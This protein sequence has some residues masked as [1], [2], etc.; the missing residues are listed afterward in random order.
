MRQLV[1][2]S[3]IALAVGA[4]IA[5]IR[6]VD[7]PAR[8]DERVGRCGICHADIELAFERGKHTDPLMTC[9]LCHGE[10]EDHIGV[11]DNSVKPE[12]PLRAAKEVIAL[13]TGCHTQLAAH[14]Q[15][16]G[17]VRVP[18]GGAE[19]ERCATC[20]SL[21][22]AAGPPAPAPCARCHDP[23]RGTFWAA[24]TDGKG[25]RT[26]AETFQAGHAR[27]WSWREADD[28]AV[29]EQEGGN[30]V[31]ALRG[32][33]VAGES[34][35]RP[36]SFALWKGSNFSDFEL[37]C[38]VRCTDDPNRQGRSLI[39]VFDYTDHEH[40]YY[41]HLCNRSDGV[42]N[43]VLI[44]NGEDRKALLPG[45]KAQPTLLDAEWHR[46]K[47]VRRAS[48]GLIEVYYDDMETPLHRVTDKT[49]TWGLIGIGT[50][51]SKGEFDD[52][53]VEGELRA[54]PTSTQ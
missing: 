48:D 16:P 1:R 46:V 19:P 8:A 9:V 38:R 11:E 27:K 54:A 24:E 53:K 50:G 12:R 20:H 45:R 52:L 25:Q 21:P 42:Y 37:T 5:L 18:P 29:I 13:C 31:F 47:I 32:L 39:I 34:P 43:N 33:G 17:P 3:V 30:R 7:T 40:F 10:S 41:L 36:M 22:A 4:A 15:E 2:L 35:R 44:V 49:L 6:P 14:C 23:H 51:F 26:M 28:W